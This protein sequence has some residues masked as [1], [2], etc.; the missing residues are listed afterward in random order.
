M[1][2]TSDSDPGA[3]R[4]GG[5]GKP[6]KLLGRAAGGGGGGGGNTEKIFGQ[7]SYEEIQS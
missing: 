6:K 1:V 4:G 2:R 5:G 3:G 7:W